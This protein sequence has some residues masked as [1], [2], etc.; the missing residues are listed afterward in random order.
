MRMVEGVASPR[1]PHEEVRPVAASNNT[2]NNSNNKNSNIGK[3]S[4]KGP[5]L[6]PPLPLW[7]RLLRHVVKG[8]AVGEADLGA[9]DLA[10]DRVERLLHLLRRRRRRKR[11]SLG[12]SLS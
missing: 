12:E 2:N 11:A 6:L 10:E 3:S 8:G 5:S 4:S 9:E 1:S 7:P